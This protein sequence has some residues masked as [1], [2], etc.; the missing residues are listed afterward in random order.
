MTKMAISS[1]GSVITVSDTHKEW[2]PTQAWLAE[3]TRTTATRMFAQAGLE[4]DES[5]NKSTVAVH[6][7]ALTAQV[8]KIFG[9]L[10]DQN[11]PELSVSWAI[12]L[13]VYLEDLADIGF[14]Y[15]LPRESRVVR[16]A[17]CWGRVAGGLPLELSEHPEDGIE[18]LR[19]ESVGRVVKMALDFAAQEQGTEY[20]E[21]FRWGAKG[22]DGLFTELCERLPNRVASAPP[23]DITLYYNSQYQRARNR[24]DRWQSRFP[25]GA[26]VVARTGS[27]PAHYSV[28]VRR[29]GQRVAAWFE[30]SRE[31][32]RKWVLLAEKAANATNRVSARA[33]GDGVSFFLPDMLPRA[34]LAGLFACAARVIPAE[35][36]WT[37]DVGAEARALLGILLRSANIELI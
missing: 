16:L 25:S 31:E 32:A 4:G 18:S 13:L 21:V 30:V 23:E 14:G 24:G 3:V 27:Q 29:E 36:G 37:L 10:F 5:G 12:D 1:G 9:A 8:Y 20:S 33:E 2:R 17:E 15:Y 6:R 7:G 34:W 28:Q 26:F 22:V 19:G 11:A 35:K